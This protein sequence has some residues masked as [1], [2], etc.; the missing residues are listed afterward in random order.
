MT[1]EL[2]DNEFLEEVINYEGTVVV[3]FFAEWCEPCKIMSPLIDSLADENL[4]NVKVF[5]MDVDK[6]DQT[7]MQYGI[8]SIPTIMIFKNGELKNTFVGITD[9]DEIKKGL[10]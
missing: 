5:K 6:N 10:Q 4:S 1:K 7:A 2:T 9:I 8:M 3:D